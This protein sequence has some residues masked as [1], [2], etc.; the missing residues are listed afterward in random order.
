MARSSKLE[1]RVVALL[2]RA[3]SHHPIT[4]RLSL[5]LA[6]AA[7][8]LLTVA[9]VLQPVA[10]AAVV[11]DAGEQPAQ[12]TVEKLAS[13]E[14][15]PANAARKK[16]PAD[17]KHNAAQNPP[18]TS[19]K[20]SGSEFLK[21]IREAA[22]P[23][24]A[25]M[26]DK[27]GYRL[28][29]AQS[30]HR[31]APPFDPIRMT[32]YRIGNPSQSQA[33]PAGPS[34]MS[35]RWEGNALH[36]WGM[37]FGGSPHDGYSLIGVADA[38]QGL[39][40]QQVVGPPELLN[41]P[42]PGDWVSRPG[43][44]DETFARELQTILRDEL[45][46]AIRLQF[47]TQR[48][49]VYVAKGLYRFVALPGQRGETELY[50]E[51]KTEKMNEV[52]IFGKQLAPNSGAGGGTGDFAEFLLWLGRWIDMPIVDEVQQPPRQI[53][54]ILHG[55]LRKKT[56]N[57]KEDHDPALVLHNIEA[58]TGVHFVSELRTVKSLVVERGQ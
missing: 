5:G 41:A 48:R 39:K 13:A 54:W 33:I 28:T 55:H 50:L 15:K 32:Y 57:E 49:E 7:A 26:A 29:P 53:S 17:A 27:H 16:D 25:E 23:I 34:A 9:A 24:L 38:I 47:R 45:K 3:R 21:R 36:R 30:I 46:L 35:F 31:V 52:Q 43:I 4:V 18:D 56:G 42:I 58:Q 51:N 11:P 40:S 22:E 2:D 6:L 37:T 1:E 12:G 44:S 10:R 14:S 20:D 19:K 8:L